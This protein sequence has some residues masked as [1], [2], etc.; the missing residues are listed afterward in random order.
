MIV[1]LHKDQWVIQK[2][3][4]EDRR[5]YC[6]SP[7]RVTFSIADRIYVAAS[8]ADASIHHKTKLL[9]RISCKP[10]PIPVNPMFYNRKK[11]S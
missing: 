3:V 6:R 8:S 1:F 5:D 7:K 4:K 10:K 9:S 11:D 2:P